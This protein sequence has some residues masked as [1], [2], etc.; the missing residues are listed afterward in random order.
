MSPE[1]ERMP[2]TLSPQTTGTFF[3]PASLSRRQASSRVAWSGMVMVRFTP[4]SSTPQSMMASSFWAKAASGS[5][6]Y[7]KNC[8]ELSVTARVRSCWR[9]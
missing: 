8:T 9:R 6:K 3:T 5:Q 4:T 7:S 1:R 2:T